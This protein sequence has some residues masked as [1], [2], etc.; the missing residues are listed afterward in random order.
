VL[1]LDGSEGQDPWLMF[2]DEAG[3][4]EEMSYGI[5]ELSDSLKKTILEIAEKAIKPK[6]DTGY[7]NLN[8]KLSDRDTKIYLKQAFINYL[9]LLYGDLRPFIKTNSSNDKPNV[10]KSNDDYTPNGSPIDD[11]SYVNSKG[12]DS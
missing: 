8:V 6:E 4:I 5:R 10:S 7:P 3:N 11:Q 2:S 9:V 1:R 12:K